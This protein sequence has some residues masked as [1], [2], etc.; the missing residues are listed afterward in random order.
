M[1]LAPDGSRRI[2][3]DTQAALN[4][5]TWPEVRARRLEQAEGDPLVLWGSYRRGEPE[6]P[7]QQGSA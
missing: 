2:L 3:D 1:R 6:H 7:P 5:E 4:R